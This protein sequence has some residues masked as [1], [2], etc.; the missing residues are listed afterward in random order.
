MKRTK[1]AHLAL[2]LVLAASITAYSQT[3]TIEPEKAIDQTIAAGETHSYNMTLAAGMYGIVDLDQKGINLT[4]TILSTDGQ[5]LRAA[6]LTGVGF[7]EEISLVAQGTTTYRVEVNAGEKP[8][9]KGIYSLKLTQI[10]P[11]TDDDQLRVQA[12]TLSEDGVQSLINQTAT[13]KA[14]ALDKFQK[15]ISLWHT[16][17]DE[18]HEAQAFYYV[19]YTAN[20][21]GQYANAAEAAEKGLPL[22]RAAA[23][24]NLE[25][26][27][28][29]EL[30]SSFNNR[31][32]KKKGL[33]IFLDALKLRSDADPVGRATTLSNIAIAY[34]GIGERRKSLGYFEQFAPILGGMGERLKESTTLGNMCVLHNDLGEFKPALELCKQ[35]LE[36]KR[37]LKDLAGQAVTLSNTGNIYGDMGDYETALDLYRQALAIDKSINEDSGAAIV[38]SNIGWTYGQLGEYQKAIDYYTQMI[39]PFRK[40]NRKD[41]LATLFNNI[42]V[43]YAKLNDFSK[44]LEFHLQALELRPEQDDRDGRALSLSNIASCYS[45]LG[46]KQKALN[47]YTQSVTLYRTVQNDRK[48]ATALRNFGVFQGEEG[49]T[50]KALEYLNEARTLSAKVSDP[51]TEAAVL[52]EIAKIE[53]GRGD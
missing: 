52:S 3:K 34:W 51:S 4:L 45:H 7:A 35:A 28:L 30:G 42:G 49:Q 1:N 8:V 31:G 25:A 15:S 2:L 26:Y 18:V 53:F 44:A 12:Q 43:D 6:D 13:S 29:D 17:K 41:G 16:M 23:D 40:R 32:E 39:E 21:M 5:K 38:M 46:D 47:Y 14:E 48:L 20:Q 36:M 37:E 10:H 22:A 33:D 24:K 11:A 27:L 50:T 19:A 9:V